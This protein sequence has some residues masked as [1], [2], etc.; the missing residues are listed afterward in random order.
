MHPTRTSS[1][2]ALFASSFLAG[3]VALFCFVSASSSAGC[4][5]ADT[6]QAPDAAQPPCEQGPFV[7]CQPVAGDAPGCDTAG[8]TSPVLSKIPQARYPVGCVVNYVGPRDEQGDCR[9]ASVCK[10]AVDQAAPTDGGVVPDPEDAG[11]SDDA[12][13]DAEAGPPAPAPT[14]TPA[15]PAWQCFP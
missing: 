12:G 8:T 11:S 15:V 14:P 4:S 7:F 6:T 1:P 9:L 5:S 3:A 2:R 10:C 13:D